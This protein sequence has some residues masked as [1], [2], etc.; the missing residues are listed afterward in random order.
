MKNHPTSGGRDAFRS[1]W[2][3]KLACIGS[4][5]GMGNI[6]M[7]PSRVSAY[8]A[9]FLLPY[10]LFVALIASTGVI[11]EMAFGRAAGGGPI[12][13]FGEAARRR[14]G[15][16][17]WGEAL[18]L[19][20][21]AGSL[22]MA[23]GYSVVVGWLLK[24]AADALT[25]AWMAN[26]GVEAFDAAFSSA[27]SAWGNNLWQTAAVVI[28]M[29]IMALGIGGGI[30][31]AN[32]VMMPLFFCLFLGLAVY[33]STLP[34]AGAG[35]R[36]MFLMDPAG[37][38]DPMVW[39]YALGQAFFS[40]SVAGNGT[41]IYGSYLSREADVPASAR[42]V[43][44]FDT[45]AAMLAALVIIPAMATAGETLSR[46]GPGLLFIFLPN[47]F[48][49]MPGGPVIM[50]VFF[51]AALFAGMTS[52][53]NLFEAPIATVQEKFRLSRLA[54]VGAVGAVGLAAS[55]AI[56]GIVSPWMDVC[57]IYACPVGALLAGVFFFWVWGKADCLSQVNLA[58]R[59]PLGSWFYPLAKYAFCGV[60]VI[61]LVMGA[62]KGGI[63]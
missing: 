17:R 20:P 16:R 14:T 10:I 60:T 24:Y 57:S 61:V 34:G 8:G 26:R 38:L 1:R 35:Y 46:S 62:I 23:I 11:G 39:V 13:A 5:V 41:L 37:L 52:L 4:A 58:R 12:V 33:I 43:A 3:F 15:S 53:I 50:A 28:A 42:T 63:G 40:L 22:A 56:Q 29:V 21:V 32:K 47:L 27:A 19:V 9:V 30:E 49:E 18:G 7:F 48:R 55:L 44:L 36:Y 6:W 59:K 31:K 51:V 25:G 54:A 45:L 2:G